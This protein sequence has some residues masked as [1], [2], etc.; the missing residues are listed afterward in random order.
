MLN[1]TET[2]RIQYISM[3]NQLKP[4]RNTH[5]RPAFGFC[6]G[7]WLLLLPRLRGAC[8][9]VS[10]QEDMPRFPIHGAVKT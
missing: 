8:R 7:L 1:Q 4:Q 2:S 9:L 6:L 3:F 5:A 10:P